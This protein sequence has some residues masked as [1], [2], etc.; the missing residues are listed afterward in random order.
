MKR[1]PQFWVLVVFFLGV[2]AMTVS[3]QA[4]PRRPGGA[5]GAPGGFGAFGQRP[6]GFGGGGGVLSLLRSELVRTEVGVDEA[7]AEKVR[8]AAEE[9]MRQGRE[10]REGMG[11]FRE[12]SQEE[13]QKAFEK[14]RAEMEE[15]TKALE[16]KV[17][18]IIGADKFKRLK[19][20]ELQLAGV[21]ALNRPDVAKDL[22]LSEETKEKINAAFEA[23]REEMRK[24]FEGA[25]DMSESERAGLRGKMTGLREKL[26]KDVMS[27]LSAEEK[28]KL[29]Q[30]MGEPL[31]EEKMAQIREQQM[32][33]GFGR[34]GDRPG[35]RGGQRGGERGGQRG[36]E[37]PRRSAT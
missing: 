30:M 35:D 19:Q 20:M 15:R 13:R 37:R 8:T 34:G 18:E 1:S 9:A 3:V 31:S 2:L 32:R 22:G 27:L 17:R 28:Q 26:Q 24:T 10:G 4:Q 33:A 21:N 23:N 7:T 6:G 11:S 29:G 16:E 12:M 36:G 25:R 5:G 14:M